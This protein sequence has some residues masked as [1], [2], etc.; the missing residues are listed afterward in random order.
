MYFV[1]DK[2]EASNFVNMDFTLNFGILI[3]VRQHIVKML[4]EN[5]QTTYET[6]ADYFATIPVQML[7]KLYRYFSWVN[8]KL[9]THMYKEN[10]DKI[11]DDLL[12][13]FKS[14]PTLV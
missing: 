12:I 7:L 5:G 3:E 9:H 10:K 2:N 1:I 11:T 14:G 6:A 8:K 13:D 4:K